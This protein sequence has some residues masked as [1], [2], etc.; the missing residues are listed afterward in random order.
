LA[1]QG[2]DVR[3]GIVNRSFHGK[4]CML[5]IDNTHEVFSVKTNDC[6]TQVIFQHI[7]VQTEL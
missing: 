5:L 7:A 3:A 2:I 1:S 4:I 6:I